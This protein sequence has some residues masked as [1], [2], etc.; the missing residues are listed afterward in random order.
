MTRALLLSIAHDRFCVR[1]PNARNSAKLCGIG[2]VDVDLFGF[3]L[4]GPR[5]IVG[6]QN[7]ELPLH[8]F[9]FLRRH[10]ADVRNAT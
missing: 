3:L 9:K 5:S 6:R 2:P 7:G 8:L 10:I 4:M 1:L